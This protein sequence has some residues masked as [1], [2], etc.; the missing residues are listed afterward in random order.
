MEGFRIGD[1]LE[2]ELVEKFIKKLI[3]H[4]SEK[5]SE[6][7]HHGS[8]DDSCFGMGSWQTERELADSVRE[9]FGIPIEKDENN[10]E[11]EDEDYD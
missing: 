8:C 5:T 7:A 6:A 2:E 3:N 10:Y 9:M 1:N 11:D 4:I